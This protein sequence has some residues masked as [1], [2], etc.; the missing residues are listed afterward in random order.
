MGCPNSTL[1]YIIQDVCHERYSEYWVIINV[2]E[3]LWSWKQYLC[4]I[5][6]LGCNAFK[7]TEYIC[8]KIEGNGN[9]KEIRREQVM[10]SKKI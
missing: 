7:L 9:T 2:V 5:Q 1:C 8:C 3:F 6:W 10:N 4:C